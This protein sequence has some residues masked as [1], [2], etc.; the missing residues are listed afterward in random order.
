MGLRPA[1]HGERKRGDTPASY[2]T[3]AG[4]IQQA[5]PSFSLPSRPGFSRGRANWINLSPPNAKQWPAAPPQ[6][7]RGGCESGV[8]SMSA[9]IKNPC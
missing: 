2:R 4:R 7:N 9:K 5:C 8:D 3:A 6:G 1:D